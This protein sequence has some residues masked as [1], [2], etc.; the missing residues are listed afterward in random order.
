MNGKNVLVIFALFI[1]FLF[2]L[3][4]FVAYFGVFEMN[5]KCEKIILCVTIG[6]VAFIAILFAIF[7]YD[8]EY[9]FSNIQ[10]FADSRITL[11]YSGEDKNAKICFVKYYNE[12]ELPNLV[13]NLKE[14]DI[15]YMQKD[16]P[17]S[18][19]FFDSLK[20]YDYT[21]T[22]PHTNAKVKITRMPQTEDKSK[23]E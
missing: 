5:Q 13:K 11:V 3:F 22:F 10:E 12:S 20:D 9:S 18:K 21:V 2:S 7:F 1:A 17:I 23:S 15:I 14:N 6:I 19:A 8:N 16:T 4:C